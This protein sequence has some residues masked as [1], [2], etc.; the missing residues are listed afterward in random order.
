MCDVLFTSFI[1][2]VPL[3]LAFLRPL[4]PIPQCDGATVAHWYFGPAAAYARFAAFFVRRAGLVV[5]LL[6]IGVT[7]IVSTSQLG[8]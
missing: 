4:P 5:V 6:S 1:S 8:A 2:A 3:C 7:L